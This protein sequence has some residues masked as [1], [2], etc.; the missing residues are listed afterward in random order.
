MFC[1]LGDKK[2]DKLEAPRSYSVKQGAEYGEVPHVGGKASMQF[3]AEKLKEVNIDIRLSVEF[4][5]PGETID[6][7]ETAKE[8]GEILP[9]ITG[10]GFFE[11]RFVITDIDITYVRTT[12]IGK[13]LTADVEISLKE[14]ITP[15]GSTNTIPT[16]QAEQ[17]VAISQPPESPVKTKPLQIASNI[18]KA[19]EAVARGWQEVE[20]VKRN[21]STAKSA[22]RKI[23]REIN[24]IKYYYDEAKI[25]L[26][27]ASKLPK[28]A[29]GLASSLTNGMTNASGINLLPSSTLTQM[30]GAMTGLSAAQTQIDKDAVP[31]SSFIA[32]K[33]GGN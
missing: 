1:Q 32:S 2:F 26:N 3:T 10:D 19:R 28:R 12:D 23:N 22:V 6:Y 4:C 7:F 14:Y 33:E 30:Q 27:S 17:G 15:P 11:G 13:L 9:L 31:V 24:G 21:I 25:M 20:K 18:S 8:T 5:D 16:G 29:K